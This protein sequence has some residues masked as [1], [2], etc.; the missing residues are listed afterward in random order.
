MLGFWYGKKETKKKVKVTCH[1]V[2]PVKRDL[3]YKR[4]LSAE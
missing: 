3:A 1:L 2:I 4:T